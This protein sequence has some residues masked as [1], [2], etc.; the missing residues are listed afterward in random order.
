MPP[1]GAYTRVRVHTHTGGRAAAAAAGTYR[2]TSIGA[3][4]ADTKVVVHA[5]YCVAGAE[6]EPGANGR[7]W[8]CVC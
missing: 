2:L 1:T 8:S 7:C 6:V 3:V 5:Y 4:W